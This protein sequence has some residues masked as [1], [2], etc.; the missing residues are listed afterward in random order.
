MILPTREVVATYRIHKGLVVFTRVRL[1]DSTTAREFELCQK[2]IWSSA[3][4]LGESGRT[5][6]EF[7]PNFYQSQYRVTRFADVPYEILLLS[8]WLAA[9]VSVFNDG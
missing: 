5:V 6:A 9:V 4:F 8:I 3:L 2:R 7:V 1:V